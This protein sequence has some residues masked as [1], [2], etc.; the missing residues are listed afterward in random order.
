MYLLLKKRAI[1]LKEES[2]QIQQ[3][4]RSSPKSLVR[5]S[6]DNLWFQTYSYPLANTLTPLS[7]AQIY[8]PLHSDNGTGELQ[9]AILRSAPPERGIQP[10]V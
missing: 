10:T 9:V 7:S 3:L 2:Y 1:D 6:T 8:Y 5:S 4:L